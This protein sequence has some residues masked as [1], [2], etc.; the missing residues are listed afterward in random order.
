MLRR[1]APRVLTTRELPRNYKGGGRLEICGNEYHN[2]ASG[3]LLKIREHGYLSIG[4]RFSSGYGNKF[5]INSNSSFGEDNLL[6]W[7]CQFMDNDSHPILDSHNNLLN[8]SK[9]FLVGNNI[10]VGSNCTL[11]KGASIP[12]GS[13]IASGSL[14]S[15]HLIESNAIYASSVIL[16]KSVFWKVQ[17]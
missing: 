2:F 10:W 12:N 5:F 7:D 1:N 16:K 11:L 17:L 13:I 4:N 14:I 9:G 15:K 6:S 8:P 3:T